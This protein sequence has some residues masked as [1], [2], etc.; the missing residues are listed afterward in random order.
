MTVSSKLLAL[1]S[2][3]LSYREM[4]QKFLKV[5]KQVLRSAFPKLEGWKSSGPQFGKVVYNFSLRC[6]HVFTSLSHLN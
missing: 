4:P 5:G 3:M 2:F 6:R 1:Q